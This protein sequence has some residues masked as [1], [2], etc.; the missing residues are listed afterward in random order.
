VLRLDFF[1]KLNVV[2]LELKK[3]HGRDEKIFRLFFDLMTSFKDMIDRD[4]Q[5]D[6][7]LAEEE[8]QELEK[9]VYFLCDWEDSVVA[10]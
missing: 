4:P 2:L 9:S 10:K 6:E 5:E 3:E 8:W 7:D 1:K